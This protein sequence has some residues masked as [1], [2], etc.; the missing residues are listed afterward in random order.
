[1]SP[2][3]GSEQVKAGQG[4]GKKGPESVSWATEVAVREPVLRAM[5]WCWDIPLLTLARLSRCAWL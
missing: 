2:E 1:M 3:M 4:H 5:L